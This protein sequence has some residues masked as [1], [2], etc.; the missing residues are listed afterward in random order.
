MKIDREL[1]REAEQ[2][3][4]KQSMMALSNR[5][6]PFLFSQSQIDL[7]KRLLQTEAGKGVGVPM[8]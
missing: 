7:L 1:I 4:I 6:Y 5:K 2:L 8:V 3:M